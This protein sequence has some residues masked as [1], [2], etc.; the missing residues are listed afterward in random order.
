MSIRKQKLGTKAV[1][2]RINRWERG[3]RSAIAALV[4]SIFS[5]LAQA[6]PT[7]TDIEFSARPGSKFEVRVDFDQAPPD[8]KAYT[9]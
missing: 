5:G 7:V 1:G 8:M 4:L 2:K 6:A 3:L 9:I